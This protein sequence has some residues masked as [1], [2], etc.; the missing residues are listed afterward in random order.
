MIQINTD[1]ELKLCCHMPHAIA[2][3]HWISQTITMV[4]SQGS[5]SNKIISQTLRNDNFFE[6]SSIYFI[7]QTFTLL[8]IR[9]G[10][11][12]GPPDNEYTR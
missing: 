7:G 4:I 2:T 9:W 6:F 11:V 3:L 5:I 8:Q 1:I 10:L 12:I